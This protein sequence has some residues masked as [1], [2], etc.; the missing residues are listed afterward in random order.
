MMMR[1][2]VVVFTL[3]LVG[4]GHPL[5]SVK[6]TKARYDPS[7][8]VSGDVRM[9][10]EHIIAG[11][12]L[13]P[14]DSLGAIGEYLRAT[15]SALAQLRQHPNDLDAVRDYD[16]ALARV[17]SAIRQGHIDAW[18]QP[19]TVPGYVVTHRKD[20]RVLWNPVDYEFIPCDEL[21]VGGTAFTERA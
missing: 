15:E 10:D 13:R 5:A 11:E 1:S 3:V 8:G 18:S 4:C 7:V 16:F 6:N 17:F 20:A 14:R 19:L 12:K 9:A 2:L 21:T